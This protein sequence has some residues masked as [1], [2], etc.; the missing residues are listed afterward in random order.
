MSLMNLMD[1]LLGDIKHEKVMRDISEDTVCMWLEPGENGKWMRW[2]DQ[3][4]EVPP[5]SREALVHQII[6]PTID[7]VCYTFMLSLLVSHEKPMLL[8][9]PTDT[10]KSVYITLKVFAHGGSPPKPKKC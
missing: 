10:G 6:V 2:Q 9:G 5:I 3:L 1:C 4:D 8:I 7:T